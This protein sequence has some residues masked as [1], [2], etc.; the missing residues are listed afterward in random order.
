M[1][2]DPITFHDVD[3]AVHDRMVKALEDRGAA[4][5][6]DNFSLKFA[7][8]TVSVDFDWTGTELILTV[9]KKPALLPCRAANRELRKVVERFGAT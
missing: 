7:G 2:C 6:E 4:I 8:T 9:I 3:E 5:T 1:A